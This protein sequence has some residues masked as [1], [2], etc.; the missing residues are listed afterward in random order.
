MIQKSILHTALA[1]T[2]FLG[3]IQLSPFSANE[4]LG[5]AITFVIAYLWMTE[6][7]HITLTALLIP[8][9]SIGSGLQNTKEAFS[10]F[11]DPIIFL[12]L[13]GFGLA[14]VLQAQK[15]D[16]YL[17][18][19][20]LRISKGDLKKAL[21]LLFALTA[22]LS[23]WIS[24]MATTALMLPIVMGLIK[25]QQPHSETRAFSVIGIAHSATIGGL[26]TILGSPPNAIA[27]AHLQMGFLDWTL[28]V[29]PFA[30][31]LLLTAWFV[32]FKFFKPKLG[33]FKAS[34]EEIPVWNFERSLTLAVFIGTLLAW[35]FS[36][37]LANLF[38]IENGMDSL[39]AITAVVLVGLLKLVSWEE[40][41]KTTEWGVL[42][43]FGGG[44]TLSQILIKS[45]ASEALTNSLAGTLQNVPPFV[46]VLSVT[47][48]IVFLTEL[49]SNT[50]TAALLIPLFQPIAVLF[51]IE[52]ST[53]ILMIAVASSCGFMLPVATPPN[54]IAYATNWITQRQ[55]IKVGIRMNLISIFLISI[56]FFYVLP[57]FQT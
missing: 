1:A 19:Q 50:A 39:I 41:Q 6:A 4:N 55:M 18:L 54:T 38:G 49:T 25:T 53:F 5:L 36:P 17:A 33:A 12:F 26:I 13:G 45:G 24:N 35:I 20:I 14:A 15:I 22:F 57:L 8:V 10:S 34:K 52:N 32:L 44:L 48:F 28:Q 29:T 40:I 31:C 7:Y 16:Q 21:L 2:S 42:V 51:N 3:I 23:M 11:A 27:A 46:L 9:L 47:V 30:V 37:Q 56:Y 43:L